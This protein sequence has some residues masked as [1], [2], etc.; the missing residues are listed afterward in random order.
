M[1][2]CSFSPDQAT[3]TI[4]WHVLGMY[5][6]SFFTGSLIARF[7]RQTMALIGMA[8]LTACGI[9]AL[10]GI[11]IL[12]FSAALI[13]L[14]LGWN[15]AYISATTM[16][17]DCHTPEERGKTQAFNDLVVFG[18]VAGTSY[19]SGR[20]A[21]SVGWQGVNQS[22]FPFVAIAAVLV[23]ATFFMGRSRIKAA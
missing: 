22:V 7:G 11:S 8:L 16:V 4:R 5:V 13:A 2:A 9:I 3:E 20:L 1:A 6:P 21:N 19:L 12:H 14:G 17:T 23:I 15:F 18:F 10:S